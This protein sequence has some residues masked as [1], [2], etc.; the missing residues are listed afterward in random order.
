M[1]VKSAIFNAPLN[2]RKAVYIPVNQPEIKATPAIAAMNGV[3]RMLKRTRHKE[4]T[5]QQVK[6]WH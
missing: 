5:K 1:I 2:I 4:Y 3:W 6:K